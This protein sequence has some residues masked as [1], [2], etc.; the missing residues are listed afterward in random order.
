MRA[1]IAALVTVVAFAAVSPVA[2]QPVRY[3][4]AGHVEFSSGQVATDLAVALVAGDDVV[5]STTTDGSGRF[6]FRDVALA[7]TTSTHASERSAAGRTSMAPACPST[8]QS[9]CT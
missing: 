6:A 2:A 5:V 7:A 4:V 8:S 9:A 1:M 3:V